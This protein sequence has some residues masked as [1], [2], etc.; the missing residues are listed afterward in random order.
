MN[1]RT[2]NRILSHYCKKDF[3]RKL[4]TREYCYFNNL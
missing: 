2:L 1:Y 4:F 3:W